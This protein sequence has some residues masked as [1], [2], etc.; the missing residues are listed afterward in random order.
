MHF[1]IFFL[2]YEKKFF[3]TV[4]KNIKIKFIEL[5]KQ[6][7]HSNKYNKFYFLMILKLK[8]KQLFLLSTYLIVILVIFI[9]Q[10]IK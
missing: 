2:K 5:N 1:L 8:I 7:K 4:L 10:N 6:W 3:K 9:K